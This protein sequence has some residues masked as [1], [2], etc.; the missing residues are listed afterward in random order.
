MFTDP[1]HLK[2][3]DPGHL[4]GNTVF[5]Y[6]EA[7]A[8]PE[9]FAEFWPEYAGIEELEAHYTRGG[10][11]DVAVKKFLQKVL[12]A[13]LAPIREKRHYWEKHIPDVYDILKKGTD[14]ARK[15]A[16]QTLSDVRNAMKINYFE[17]A[18][19][20]AEHVDKYKD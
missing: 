11:G 5:T 13:E 6:L 8:T 7:F 19:L 14:E 9:H 20:I 2:K 17:D 1:L 10:L 4:E 12:N 18:A 15:V 16:S 3:D